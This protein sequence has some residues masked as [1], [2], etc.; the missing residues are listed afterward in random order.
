[1]SPAFEYIGHRRQ[2]YGWVAC[3]SDM[4]WAVSDCPNPGIPVIWMAVRDIDSDAHT[5]R[6][7]SVV[8][9]S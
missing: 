2:E 8:Q 7:G 6:F 5:P 1:M 3:V 4:E 9:L